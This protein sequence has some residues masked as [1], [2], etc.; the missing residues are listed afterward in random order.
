MNPFNIP[1]RLNK[2]QWETPNIQ[3]FPLSN[4]AEGYCHG[5]CPSP[6]TVLPNGTRQR[7]GEGMR[8][9][10]SVRPGSIPQ[11]T[12]RPRSCQTLSAFPV[13]DE[14]VL[15]SSD[16]S[17]AVSLNASAKSI[18]EC[19]DGEHTVAD[20]SQ[21]LHHRYSS[22]SNSVHEDVSHALGLFRQLNLL[23]FESLSVVQRNPVK[24]VVGIEDKTYFHWQLP[25]LLESFKDKLP[26]GR[27]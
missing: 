7:S 27:R 12:A 16:H 14:L 21:K 11:D 10:S 13:A 17:F 26:V 25:I 19:C 22:C 20:V 18:W 5:V 3:T 15:L 23:K 2:V 9:S 24:F 6:S 4:H 8:D 1:W